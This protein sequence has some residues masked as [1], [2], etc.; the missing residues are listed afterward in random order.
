MAKVSKTLDMMLGSHLDAHIMSGYEFLMQNYEAGDKICIFGFSRGAYTARALAGMI[1]KVGLLPICNHQQVPFAYKMYITDDLTGWKQSTAFKRA[2]SINVEIEFV[3]VWDTVDSVGL[4]PRRLPFTQVDNNIR[5]FRHALSL[6]EHRVRFKPSTWYRPTHHDHQKGLKSHEM[7][8]SK[9]H[10]ITAHRTRAGQL[11]HLEHEYSVEAETVTDVEE[12]WFAGCH[13]DIGGG[14]VVNGTRNSLARIPLRWM[15]RQCFIANT[16]I[17]FHK[18][19]LPKVGLDP[20][21]LYPQVLPRPPMVLQDP[22]V[23]TIPVPEPKVVMDDRK[24]V[25][26]TDGGCFVNEAEEDLADALTPMYDQLKLAK[27]WWILEMLPQKIQYQ[28]SDNDKMVRKLTVNMGRPRHVAM[29]KKSGIKI[30]RSVKIRME[31]QGIVGQKGKY[32]P[33]VELRVQPTWVD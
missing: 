15:I 10:D 28:D 16:G 6:D 21:T 2:F 31:A 33:K 5:Y 9:G 22:K 20:A 14:S 25:V 30:H 23:H 4:I 19:T 7:P 8:R 32:S 26:Y 29:Q 27:F 17:M 13:C 3:G 11:R 24:A 1:H 18:D 12:V